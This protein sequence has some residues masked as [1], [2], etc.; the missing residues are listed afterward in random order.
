MSP[1]YPFRPIPGQ[2]GPHRRGPLPAPPFDPQDYWATRKLVSSLF[3]SL[4]TTKLDKADVVDPST[5]KDDGKAADAKSTYEELTRISGMASDAKELAESKADQSELEAHVAST[6]NP[7]SVTAEQVNAYTKETI[8]AKLDEKADIVG[9]K[10]PASQLPSYVDDVLEYDT[11][12]AFPVTGEGGKIYVANDTNL[13]Y[14]WSG[15]QYVEISPSP[16]LDDTVTEK[17]PN[18][19]KSS[20][21]WSWVKSLLPK[22]LTSNYAE[23]ATV[24]SVKLKADKA[25]TLSGYGITDA[26]P[27]VED[28]NGEKT[29]VTIG[30]RKD[31][32]AGGSV[33]YGSLANGINVNASGV[34]SHAEGQDTSSPGFCSH[35]E[36]FQTTAAEDFSHA[37]GSGTGSY[38]KGSHAEGDNTFAFADYSHVA[39]RLAQTLKGHDHAYVWNGNDTRPE[40]YSSH[41]AGTFNINPVGGI[42]GFWIGEQTLDAI[43]D[44]ILE[45]KADK[46]TTLAGYGI[47]DA[48]PFVED[49]SGEKT[50][51]T[52]GSRKDGERVG[53]YSFAN[54]GGVTASVPHSHAE[55]G[56]TTASGAYSHAEG[57]TTTAS[58]KSSHSEGEGTTASGINSHAEGV[59]TTAAGPGSHAEGIVSETREEDK[60]AFAWNGDDRRE[61][62]LFPYV[63]HGAGTFNINP[64]DGLNGFF[65]GERKF[66]EILADKSD[67]ASLAPE[68]SPTSAYA[69]G[70][71]VYY[72]GNIYQCKTAIADGGEAWN[73]EHWEMM[74]LDDFFTESNSLLTGT[75]DAEIVEKGTAPDAHLE[76]PT[77]ERLKLILADNSVAYDS[78]KAL[79]YKLTSVIGDRVIAT[80][81]LTAASTDITLP[82]IAANDTTVK[83]F[84]LDVTNAYA[85]EGVA[86]DAGINIPRT[87]FKLVTRDGESLTAVTT[88]KAGKSAFICFTQKS[89]VVVDG[90]TYPCWCVIQLPFGDPS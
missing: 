52:I 66:S 43:L 13:T 36:G 64:K 33:G 35:S 56:D 80:M 34:S 11:M 60:Y 86:T 62:P 47:T 69:V 72:D 28:V 44:A 23:P 19:V 74:K 29:A 14:R 20:G 68:Y 63:S 24:A 65:I 89:P 45:N 25:T 61:Y 2:C 1:C 9:G 42:N 16:L 85:V 8:D 73:A 40:L 31:A 67:C 21:I 77:D 75:I 59:S 54:G 18:G 26:V 79:P 32:Q 76:A 55:G 15:T 83:D 58:E 46:A 30:S 78:A 10:I 5:A 22:W 38:G 41:D 57:E 6:N 17:S 71:I 39:G 53:E 50:A 90:T 37:E 51:V 49:G 12:S 81:T 48:V 87:D 88:V 70:A 4:D 84:I 82:A 3:G 27:F 7:H